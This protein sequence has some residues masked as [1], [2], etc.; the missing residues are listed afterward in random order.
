MNKVDPIEKHLLLEAIY[1]KY[2][3]DFRQYT[4][5][6]MERRLENIL[7]RQKSDTLLPLLQK[8]IQDKAFFQTL[9]PQL[10]INTT[11][12]FRD[13]VFFK[14]LKDLVFPFLQ[15]YP[16]LKFWVA[17]CSTGEEVYSLAILLQEAGLYERST[18]YAT[19]INKECLQRAK[20]GIFELPST[21]IYT[22][23]YLAAGGDRNPSHYYTADYGMA[24]FS[25][26]LRENVVF[27][28]HNL[29]TDRVFGEM[30]LILCRNVMIYFQRE[31]QN[32]VLDLFLGSLAH[33]GFLGVGSKED[34][35]FSPAGRYFESL[36][37]KTHLYQ[38]C[39]VAR[40]ERVSS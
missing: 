36:G 32:R 33:R 4:S 28:E 22:A 34:I 9:L 29:A 38:K 27:S 24:I 3:Y 8:A 39:T 7:M 31:L 40:T 37:V 10:T 17:G 5:N 25:P 14:N 12:F 30:H 21:R 19:D 35:R 13:P 15:T 1:L 20:E 18:I 2:G 23:N 11:E 16:S 26:S 6:S